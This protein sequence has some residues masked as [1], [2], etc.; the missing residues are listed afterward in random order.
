M[1]TRAIKSIYTGLANKYGEQEAIERFLEKYSE[2]EGDLMLILSGEDELDQSMKIQGE[3]VDVEIS[4]DEE[5][6]EEEEVVEEEVKAQPAIV[7]QPKQEVKKEPK[8]KKVKERVI[9]KAE[10][11]RQ[12]YANAEDK[13]RKVI[14]A[15]FVS[16]VGLTTAGANT[17]FNTI[18]KAAKAAKA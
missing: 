15:R 12:I 11:A 1:E 9:S 3:Q 4:E 17:Y 16:E 6:L 8:V 7:E 5:F 18:S 2:Y 14:T 10:L 13:S